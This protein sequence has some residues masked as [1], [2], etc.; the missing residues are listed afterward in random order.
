MTG[1]PRSCSAPGPP[2]TSQCRGVAASCCLRN[3][4]RW[5]LSRRGPVREAAVAAAGCLISPR[6]PHA[7]KPTAA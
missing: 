7:A 4:R 3:P 1:L 6:L 5:A 2:A